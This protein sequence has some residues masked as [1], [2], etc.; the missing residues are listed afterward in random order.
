MLE[1]NT[2][3]LSVFICTQILLHFKG[4]K[5][6]FKNLVDQKVSNREVLVESHKK[7]YSRL[8]ETKK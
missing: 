8:K 1:E 3:V 5:K 2:R 6:S 7:K 4:E